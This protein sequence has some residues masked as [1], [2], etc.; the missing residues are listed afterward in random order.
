MSLFTLTSL[1]IAVFLL[2]ASP[3]PGV[4][5]VISRSVASGFKPAVIMITGI[6]TG[7]IIYLMSAIFGL[8]LVAQ[9]MGE[10]FIIVKICGGAYL[11][12]LGFKIW[13]SHP[14]EVVANLRHK[15]LSCPGYFFSGLLITLSNPKVIL[16]YCGFLPA[17]INLNTLQTIDILL[18]SGV[19]S[20]VLS[21][22]LMIYAFIAARAG[23]FFSDQKF[24]KTVNRFAGGVMM[25]AG[26][27]VAGK[28]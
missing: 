5:A 10:L 6:V 28:T 14:S 17:F 24:S 3:G 22:V 15:A 18:I 2:A 21:A 9:A 4:F 8:S 19:V 20:V 27:A 25:A 7:D 26:I 23:Q 11:F 1:A 13:V 16:F 12:W